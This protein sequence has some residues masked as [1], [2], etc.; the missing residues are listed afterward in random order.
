MFFNERL[1]NF[2][3]H[4]TQDLNMKI[5]LNW[6][7]DYVVHGLSTEKL[8]HKLTMSGTETEAITKVNGI[9]ILDE[10]KCDFD[11]LCI[12]ACPHEAISFSED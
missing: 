4:F 6:I 9:A 10:S 8:S 2:H 7:K 11:G 5:S 3:D 12:P 1:F